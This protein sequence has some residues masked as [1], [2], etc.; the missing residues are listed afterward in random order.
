M[1]KMRFLAIVAALAMIGF[2]MAGCD[3][4]PPSPPADYCGCGHCE[5]GNRV[6]RVDCVRGYPSQCS[7]TG[8]C[9]CY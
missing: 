7:D 9:G 5:D 6:C 2:S 3:N 8:A 1:K 4:N